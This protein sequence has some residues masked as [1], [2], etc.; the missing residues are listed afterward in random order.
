MT[1]AQR[2][3]HTEIRHAIR[4][5]INAAVTRAAVNAHHQTASAIA[6]YASHLN[7]EILERLHRSFRIGRPRR[8]QTELNP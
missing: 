3:L 1:P 5:G 2:N 7:D 8:K 6:G 4:D